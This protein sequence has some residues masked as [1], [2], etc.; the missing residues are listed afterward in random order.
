[1]APRYAPCS[2]SC[3]SRT[4]D[5]NPR[6]RLIF[7]P[8]LRMRGSQSTFTKEENLDSA[9]RLQ[10]GIS[11]Q[12]MSIQ[13]RPHL[14]LTRHSINHGMTIDTLYPSVYLMGT[15]SPLPQ[16]PCLALSQAD[17]PARPTLTLTPPAWH[18]VRMPTPCVLP[19][20]QHSSHP[21]QP[22]LVWPPFQSL[23]PSPAIRPI[24]APILPH[25][26]TLAPTSISTPAPA[27][28]TR[29]FTN[30]PSTPNL[31]CFQ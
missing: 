23:A 3:H 9:S 12:P 7:P 4:Y 1:M 2:L 24:L 26:Q 25:H 19:K 21:R 28:K 31:I 6:S 8:I 16:S 18:E 15:L 13:W 27:V 20:H 29:T 5:E 17:I 14:Y 11:T 22:N 30:N 10:E